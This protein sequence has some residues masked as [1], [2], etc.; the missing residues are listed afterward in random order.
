VFLI[1]EGNFVCSPEFVE[2]ASFFLLKYKITPYSNGI[3]ITK[4]TLYNARA[5]GRLLFQKNCA[6]GIKST[7]ANIPGRRCNP[8][9]NQ[10][11]WVSL[12]R[13]DFKVVDLSSITKEIGPSLKI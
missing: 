3:R 7:V 12:E 1:I 8:I 2:V 9:D 5:V 6:N 13:R 11:E 10:I 4:I